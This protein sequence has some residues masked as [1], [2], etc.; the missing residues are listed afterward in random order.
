MTLPQKNSPRIKTPYLYLMN[1]VSNYLEKNILSNTSNVQ[2]SFRIKNVVGN[3]RIKVAAFFL[4]H[5]VLT[6]TCYGHVHTLVSWSLPGIW[7]RGSSLV[8]TK[9]C[10]TL[11]K[12]KQG[13]KSE[14]SCKIE[15][16]VSVISTD[17][18]GTIMMSL[19]NISLS[20]MQVYSQNSGLEKEHIMWQIWKIQY[21]SFQFFFTESI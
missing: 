21:L 9:F 8:S 14:I 12:R 19:P 20:R 16:N 1:L 15:Q 5:P 4:G 18:N 6:Q 2:W 13:D 7:A 10:P 11:A 17:V 3:I